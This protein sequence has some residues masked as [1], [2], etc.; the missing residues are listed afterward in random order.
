M[1]SRLEGLFILS[2]GS[3]LQLFVQGNNHIHH[4]RNVSITVVPTA[5]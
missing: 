5:P 2:V 4:P 1:I 3:S